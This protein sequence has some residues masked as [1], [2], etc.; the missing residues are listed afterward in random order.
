M[1]AGNR[2]WTDAERREVLLMA[3]LPLV[4][5]ILFTLLLSAAIPGMWFLVF[6]MST[7]C[8]YGST[9]LGVVPLLLLFKRFDRRKWFHYA[10]AG[11]L[12]VFLLWLVPVLTLS[13]FERSIGSFGVPLSGTVAFLTL[14][15]A[16]ASVGAVV[17]WFFC[18]QP[19]HAHDGI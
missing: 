13:G 17:F 16:I 12:G 15:A 8:A 10:I 4:G 6:C 14:P 2:H 5:A 9:F 3:L 11:F 1:E 19:E 7:V 18:V